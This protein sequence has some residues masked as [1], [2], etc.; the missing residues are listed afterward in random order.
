M[1]LKL[2]TY[3]TMHSS[4]CSIDHLG[5]LLSVLGKGSILENVQLHRTKCSGLIKHVIAPILLD[6][7]VNAIGQK[8]YSIIIDESTDVSVQSI[9][10]CVLNTSILQKIAYL[11]IFW[12]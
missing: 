9:C 2:A 4:I 11:L 8:G 7:L 10:A 3:I 5:V 6:N 1:E 12:V